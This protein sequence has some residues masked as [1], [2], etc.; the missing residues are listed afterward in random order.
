[1][2]PAGTG[3]STKTS[4][5]SVEPLDDPEAIALFFLFRCY[6]IALILFWLFPSIP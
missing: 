1:M 3:I 6:Q 5:S 4:A 2:F